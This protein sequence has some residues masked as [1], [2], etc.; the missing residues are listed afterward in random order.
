M[1]GENGLRRM[2]GGRLSTISNAMITYWA[3]FARIG[4][5]NGPE[6]PEWST[7][8]PSTRGRMY[9]NLPLE[10]HPTDNLDKSLF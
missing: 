2:I 4:N 8:S 1:M 7:H 10:A 5:P 6:I 9:F 3:N